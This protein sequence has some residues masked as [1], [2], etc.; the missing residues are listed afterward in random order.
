MFLQ[1]ARMCTFAVLHSGQAPSC[2]SS[3]PVDKLNRRLDTMHP[4]VNVT[5]SCTGSYDTV[6]G[7]DESV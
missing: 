7:S 4:H 2:L 1:A 5:A 3:L 6:G